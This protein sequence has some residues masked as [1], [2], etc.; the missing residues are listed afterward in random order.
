MAKIELLK[1]LRNK[2]KL[3]ERTKKILIAVFSF[4]IVIGLLFGLKHLYLAAIVN[5]RPIFRLTLYRELE[6]Q[7]GQGV[8][9]T[10]INQTLVL[11]EAKR[12]NVNISQTEIDAKIKEVEA[13]VGAQGGDL[14]SYLSSQGLTRKDFENQVRVQ[15][16]IEEV[17][18]KRIEITEEELLSYFEENKDFF[19]EGT[20]FEK[21]RNDLEES[22]RQQKLVDEFQIW[23]NE[24]RLKS[25][26]YNFL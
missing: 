13:Q 23:I 1:K 14:D 20:T 10:M 21:V 25:K 17:L 26:I 2:V 4:I 12:L 5:S 22:L 16:I 24:L 9:E 7:G 18:G 3:E 15:L 11:Q 6:K 8:L 19:E